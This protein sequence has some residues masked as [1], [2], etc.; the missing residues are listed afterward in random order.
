[1]QRVAITGTI[2][3]VAPTITTIHPAQ[4]QSVSAPPRPSRGGSTKVGATGGGP[5]AGGMET[6]AGSGTK[7]VGTSSAPLAR[8]GAD[9]A[10]LAAAGGATAAVGAAAVLWGR[11]HADTPAAQTPVEEASPV[12]T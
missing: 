6:T 3:Y 10:D 9:L 2:A 12:D 7:A 5:K 8:T 11:R 1:L 4:A